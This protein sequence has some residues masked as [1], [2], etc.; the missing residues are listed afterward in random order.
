MMETLPLEIVLMIFEYLLPEEVVRCAAVSSAW[1]VWA[2][3]PSLYVGERL[4]VCR[5]NCT[6]VVFISLLKSSR[7]RQFLQDDFGPQGRI[8]CHHHLAAFVNQKKARNMQP[9]NVLSPYSSYISLMNETI[10]KACAATLQLGGTKLEWPIPPLHRYLYPNDFRLSKFIPSYVTQIRRDYECPNKFTKLWIIVT[11][12]VLVWHCFLMHHGWFRFYT[13]PLR[14]KTQFALI[15]RSMTGLML[16]LS[17]IPFVTWIILFHFTAL[18]HD[19]PC[20]A[21][22]CWVWLYMQ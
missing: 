13:L 19:L 1:R 7:W 3:N 6:S 18:A 8:T 4:C 11:Q 9:A 17:T 20:L 2:T 12:V 14:N 16:L 5:Q 10:Q 15:H 22:S 21:P